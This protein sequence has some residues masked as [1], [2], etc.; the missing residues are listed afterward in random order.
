MLSIRRTFPRKATQHSILS[1]KIWIHKA[2]HYK[3]HIK[4][5]RSKD[6]FHMHL[7]EK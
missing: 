2:L 6:I 7:I 3:L 5:I 1:N 4:D